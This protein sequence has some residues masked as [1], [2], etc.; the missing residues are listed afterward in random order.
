MTIREHAMAAQQFVIRITRSTW[1]RL[2]S[3]TPGYRT[4]GVAAVLLTVV[5]GASGGTLLMGGADG[6]PEDAVFR[7]DE[8]VVTKQQFDRQVRLMEFLYGLRKPESSRQIDEFNRAVAKA[9]AVSAVMDRAARERGIVIATK[10][11]TDQLGKLVKEGKWQ[12]RKS[13]IE[14]LGARGLSE[15]QVV[16]E[17]K[18]QQ[19]A[20][21]LFG[22]VTSSVKP[23][24]ETDAQRYYEHNR[25]QMK[26][27][28]Q[29]EISNV[30][31][32]TREQAE[33][34]AGL[35]KNGAD[36]GSLAKRFSIDASTKDQ[37]GSLGVVSAEELDPTYAKAAFA[38]SEG[39][40]FGPVQTPQGW[41]VGKA[42]H[43]K[44]P[45]PLPF[46]AVQ[47]AIKTKLDTD[48]KFKVWN[49]FLVEQIKSAGVDY[50]PAFRPADPD[51]PPG[52]DMV[53]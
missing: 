3:V 31:V 24:T 6:L 5:A 47:D 51:A 21:R 49:A 53:R 41:S 30:V 32:E 11:A 2:A 13:F 40:V 7:A 43:V 23:A 39:S 20:A 12:E 16:E 19:S 36:I 37:G 25:A 50:A 17:I 27:P 38:A 15:L 14:A 34:V 4:H 35:A 1:R 44:K 48:A 52:R 22:R 26:S 18:R 46:S 8:I 28:E 29:R 42:E 33:H 9:M 45:V 10:A